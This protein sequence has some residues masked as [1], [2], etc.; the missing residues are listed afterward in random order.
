MAGPG[1]GPGE[2]NEQ[3]DFLF[4]LVLVGDASV[5]KTCVVQRF[6]T[7]SFSERQGSTIGVDFTMKTLEIQGKRVKLQI[8]D[9]AGQ[10]RFRTITQ[11]Y[12]RSANGAILAYDITKK[13]SF[14]SMPHWIEE[15]RKYAGSSIVQLLIGN[16]SDLSDLREVQ[17]SEAQ[18]LADRYEILCAIETSAKDSSN[19]EEAFV[20]VATELMM[21]HGGPVFNEKNTGNIKLDSKEVLEGWGCGC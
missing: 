9:T 21:R 4:K 5:G 18:L 16:K 10:E 2:P 7:G 14:L 13:N 12:Y 3:Y 15:V 1:P 6:K 11:S 19:V 8:W 20:K 17:L